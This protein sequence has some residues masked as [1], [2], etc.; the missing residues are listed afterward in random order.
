[1]ETKL[2]SG[3]NRPP[4]KGAR[5]EILAGSLN[6]RC[7]MRRPDTRVWHCPTYLDAGGLHSTPS[8]V[9]NATLQSFLARLL[10]WTKGSVQFVNESLAPVIGPF[11]VTSRSGRRLSWA[12]FDRNSGF[13]FEYDSGNP[14]VRCHPHLKPCVPGLG[15]RFVCKFKSLFRPLNWHLKY[16]R[17][18]TET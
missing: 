17:I 5:A 7:L 9:D 4:I 6:T 8:Q 2:Q 10:D 16:A 3:V 12:N 18:L 1:M 13:Q 11:S 15:R 14:C